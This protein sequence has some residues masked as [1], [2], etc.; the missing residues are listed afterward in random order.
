[1]NAPARLQR[2]ASRPPS[3]FYG[4]LLVWV[5]ARTV[6]VACGR[7]D[8]FGVTLQPVEQDLGLIRAQASLPMALA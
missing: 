8:A 7:I 4:W 6:T 5:L 3:R 2:D 1:M